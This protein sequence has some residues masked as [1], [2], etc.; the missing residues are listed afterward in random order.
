ME[1]LWK[2]GETSSV[3]IVQNLNGKTGEVF[4]FKSPGALKNLAQCPPSADG[5]IKKS[6]PQFFHRFCTIGQGRPPF[7]HSFSTGQPRPPAA[8]STALK[9][10]GPVSKKYIITHLD[11]LKTIGADLFLKL[12]LAKKLS[13]ENF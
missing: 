7:F 1:K 3:R 10:Q 5:L 4:F 13:A 11:F 12:D 2:K 9:N 6:Q 8:G